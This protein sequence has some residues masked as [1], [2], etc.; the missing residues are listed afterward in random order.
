[1]S[2]VMMNVH[3]CFTDNATYTTVYVRSICQ[4]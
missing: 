1:M 3:T 2:D 4:M